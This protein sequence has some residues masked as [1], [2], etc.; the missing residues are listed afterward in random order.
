VRD[1][2]RAS[3]PRPDKAPDAL[4][5]VS[6]SMTFETG[7]IMG[8]FIFIERVARDGTQTANR[9]TEGIGV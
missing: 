3:T 1:E 8:L 9:P 2:W 6:G 7:K 5:S 4:L